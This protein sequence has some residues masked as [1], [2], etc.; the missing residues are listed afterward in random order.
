MEDNSTPL[1]LEQQQR[2]IA[3]DH[4]AKFL[5]TSKG[6]GHSTAANVVDV[7]DLA[8]YIVTGNPYGVSHAHQHLPNFEGMTPVEVDPDSLEGDVIKNLIN[9]IVPGAF[10]QTEPTP[11][12]ESD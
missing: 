8:H 4:A 6:I 9:R 7:V 5:R 11:A 1:T 3:T 12:P 2:L 10:G